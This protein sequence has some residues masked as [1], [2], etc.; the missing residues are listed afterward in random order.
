MRIEKDI[1]VN[2]P[3]SK[4]YTLWTDFVNF[5]RFMENVESV[6]ATGA[7]TYHWKAKIGP[8]AKEWDAEVKGLVPNRSVTW[9]S[10]SGAENAGAVTLSERGNI[11]EMHVVIEYDP[12]WLEAAG[13]ILTGTLSRSVEQDLERFKRLAEGQDPSLAEGGTG[14]SAG[15]HG[16]STM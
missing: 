1:T 7:D 5:P 13:N 10:I 3:I 12:S 15:Q 8:V 6:T 9:H 11:T 14:P 2:A 16:A 4:V